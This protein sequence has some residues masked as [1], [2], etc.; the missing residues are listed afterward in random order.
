LESL[1]V[2]SLDTVHA[3][4]DHLIQLDTAQPALER[5]LRELGTIALIHD[6]VLRHGSPDLRARRVLQ[7]PLLTDHRRHQP[8]PGILHAIAGSLTA[9]VQAGGLSEHADLA[10]HPFDLSVLRREALQPDP[11]LRP[12]AWAVCYD[13]VLTDTDPLIRVRRVEAVDADGRVYQ[14]S[15]T[16]RETQ[17][18]VLVDE[19][20]DPA[21]LPA[22]YPALAQLAAA[23]AHTP[24]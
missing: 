22:T 6:F 16:A 8:L 7:L 12:L 13:D 2:F 5:R 9:D 15:R 21:D 3:L 20:P 24:T 1:P 10:L 11:G 18:V 19:R 4:V 17:P 23:A 14:L